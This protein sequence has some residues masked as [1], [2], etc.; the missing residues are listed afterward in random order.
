MNITYIDVF[1][2]M[3]D[4]EGYLNSRFTNDKL[5]LMANAYLLWAKILEPYIYSNS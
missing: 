5:H 1:T 3:T 4:S 2:A